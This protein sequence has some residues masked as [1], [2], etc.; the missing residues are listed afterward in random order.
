MGGTERDIEAAAGQHIIRRADEQSSTAQTSAPTPMSTG[1]ALT[2]AAVLRLQRLAG[3][4]GVTGMM[5][6]AQGDEGAHGGPSPVADVL[7]SPGEGLDT[8]VRADM[9][10]GF[11]ADFSDVRV[12]TDDAAHR[13][14]TAVSAHAYTSGNHIVFQRDAYDPESSAGRHTLAHELTHVLQQRSGPVD[15]TPAAGGVSVSSP[16][17][18]FERQAADMADTVT[19]GSAPVAATAA[20]SGPAVQREEADTVQRA[21]LATTVQREGEAPEEEQEEGGGGE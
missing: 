14:A 9:E 15:G 5:D 11:G 12:H 1:P 16:D 2:S 21:E 17:D 19:S 20:T 4:T 10:Q 6:E 18:R 13:S 7:S 8:G 3:N